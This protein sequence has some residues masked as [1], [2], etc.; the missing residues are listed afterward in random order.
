M[1]ITLNKLITKIILMLSN[2]IYN[3]QFFHFL[4]EIL[5]KCLSPRIH[6]VHTLQT[7]FSEVSFKLE[8]LAFLLS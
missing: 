5:H 4:N 3:I 1:I 8:D 6:K 7:V 2:I